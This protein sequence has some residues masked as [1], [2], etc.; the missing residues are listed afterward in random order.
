MPAA[1]V[2]RGGRVLF[3][4][5]GRKA[6]VGCFWQNFELNVLAQPKKSLNINGKTRVSL[7]LTAF[8]KVGVKSDEF[9]EDAAR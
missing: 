4:M 6:H 8:L 7:R 2:I 9:K 3:V 1:A 5:T